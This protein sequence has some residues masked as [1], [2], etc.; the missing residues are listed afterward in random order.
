MSWV[1]LVVLL[2]GF[3]SGV[4]ASILGIGGTVVTTPLIRALGASAIASIGSGY[5]AVGISGDAVV[6][7]SPDAVSWTAQ[8]APGLEGAQLLHVE[9]APDGTLVGVGHIFSTVKIGIQ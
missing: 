6:W 1:T 8:P 4:L 7:T 2:A 3:G 5:V 9:A